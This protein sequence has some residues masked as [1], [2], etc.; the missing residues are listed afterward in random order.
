[1]KLHLILI[2]I[3]L[4]T[5]CR[6]P[7]D[8]APQTEGTSLGLHPQGATSGP[9]PCKTNELESRNYTYAKAVVIKKT[10]EKVPG[11]IFLQCS[12]YFQVSTA[13]DGD[14]PL[15]AWRD[16]QTVLLEESWDHVD[17]IWK[18]LQKDMTLLTEQVVPSDGHKP[19]NSAPSSATTTPADAH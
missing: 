4:F 1:M 17:P 15:V 10:G 16:V 8:P 18:T 3:L 6:K 7:R 5:G 2:A 14:G 19:S 13:P 11:Y 9:T 12:G